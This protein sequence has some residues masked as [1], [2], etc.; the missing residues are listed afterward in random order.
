MA[1]SMWWIGSLYGLFTKVSLTGVR[2]S[3]PPKI[4]EIP[5]DDTLGPPNHITEGDN[6]IHIRFQCSLSVPTCNHVH[7]HA[8]CTYTRP[9][10][11]IISIYTHIDICVCINI[12]Y[13]TFISYI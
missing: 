13:I 3:F 1:C 11:P 2:L 10:H 8:P 6:K 4:D 7:M 5:Q 12:V 9:Y